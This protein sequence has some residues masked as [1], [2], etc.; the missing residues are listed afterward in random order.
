[1]KEITLA[2]E[3]THAHRHMEK[4]FSPWSLIGVLIILGAAIAWLP[5]TE[6]ALLFGGVTFFALLLVKPVLSLYVLIPI[7]PFSPWF[8]VSVGGIN[9]GL[10]EV[11][12]ASGLIAWLL[13]L[14]NRKYLHCHRQGEQA[15]T[16]QIINRKS[17]IL[18][19]PFLL[20]LA[21]VTFSW[22]NTLSLG[23]SL[24]ETIKWVEMLALY[25]LVVALLPA[26]HIKRVVAV[27][28]LTGIAQAVLGLYQFFFKVGPEGFLLF[29]G[30]F[31]RAYGTF[32]QPNP[33]GGYL[34]LILPLALSITIWGLADFA[35]SNR[36]KMFR[37]AFF[38]LTL[39]LLLA[40]LFATQS[41]SAWLGFAVAATT[42]FI[43]Y[44]KKTAA[45]VISIFVAGAII[46]LVGAFDS[47]ITG[48]NTT[49][50][51]I[52]Q[53]MA[54]AGSIF[55]ITD[56]S[57]IEVTDANFATVER[58]AHWQAAREMWRDNPWLGVGFGN[59]PVVYPAY[60]VGRWLNPLGH[61]HNYLLNTGAE[62]GLLGIT[63]YLIFWIFTFGVLWQ[64]VQRSHGFNKAVAVGGFGIIVHLHVHNLFDNLYVQGMYLHIAII[65]ALVS[66]IYQT[67]RLWKESQQC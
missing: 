67:D 34:G 20:L 44:N 42:V 21:G 11:V 1:M 64:A 57:T 29:G 3:A 56:I 16:S 43:I 25:L 55:T 9:I 62:T 61:A 4:L 45:I 59:Y 54:E 15:Q 60:A 8:A 47:G 17:Q 26:P 48:I 49:Y 50:G 23:A 52:I 63:A 2:F 18:L 12:L 40:A 33:Y 41:R 30:D 31:L 66:V 51:I 32:A 35:W 22:L 46:F 19:W 39:G 24:V 27:I 28:L 36:F 37:P 13:Q 14:S 58:L 10:M 65:L 6:M 38:C 53:R 5:P 7:I